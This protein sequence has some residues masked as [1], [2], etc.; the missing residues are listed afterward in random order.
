LFRNGFA[1][2]VV[3]MEITNNNA[4]VATGQGK[5]MLGIDFGSKRIGLALSDEARQFAMPLSVV[6]NTADYFAEIEK[7]ATDNEVREIVM[8]ESRNYKGEPNEILME[9][10][11]FKDKLESK[12]FTVYL[13]LEFMTS[14]QAERFQGK[15]DLSDASAAALILQSYL[16][17]SK[18]ETE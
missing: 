18:A 3:G 10:M 12:G 7:I 8:G 1:D 17:R 4:H 6:Q 15:T 14:M 2:I 11:E 9:S 16:D 5:R 13:E